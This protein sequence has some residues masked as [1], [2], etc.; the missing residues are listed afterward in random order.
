MTS[1]QYSISDHS[2]YCNPWVKVTEIDRLLSYVNT[3]HPNLEFTIELQL[4]GTLP[5]LEML[6][7]SPAVLS[8]QNGTANLQTLDSPLGF[9]PVRQQNTRETLFRAPCTE[10]ITP[11]PLGPPLIKV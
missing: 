10:L 11:L 9:T 7:D 6:L 8:A 1:S 3:L 4:N 2:I 5:F